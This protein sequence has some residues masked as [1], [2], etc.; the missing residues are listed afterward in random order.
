M[1]VYFHKLSTKF[2]PS[3]LWSK[4]LMVKST[5]QKFYNVVMNKYNRLTA[6]LSKCSR[7]YEPNKSKTLETKD[8]EK[9]LS[10]AP[11]ANYLSIKVGRQYS[12]L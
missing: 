3:S 8:V 5:L 7:G 11:D 6:F 9:F 4:Y 2:K 12:A 10:E 1:L